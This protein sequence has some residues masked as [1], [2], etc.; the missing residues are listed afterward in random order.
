MKINGKEI[1]LINFN[2]V[3]D[4]RGGDEEYIFEGYAVTWDT[5]DSYDTTFR[6]GAFK[7]TITER[8]DKIKVLWNHDTDEPIGKI[9]EIRE[10][11]K[12]LFVR[13]KLTK[14]VT[15]A[16]DVYKNLQAGV[17]NTLSFGF[18]PLQSNRQDGA[19]RQITEVKLYEVS[20]V[21]F[22]ANETAVITSVR[23]ET[24]EKVVKERAED[25]D[26]T[27][28]D[29]L[30]RSNGYKLMDAL[31]E[32]VDDVWYSE[33]KE[34]VISKIDE[35][36]SKF[37]SAYLMWANAYVDR[38][39][40]IRKIAMAKNEL[41]KTFI[42][43]VTESIE[44]ISSRTAFT[45]NELKSLSRGSIL[46]LESRKKLVELPESIRSAHQKERS[47]AV[48]TLCSELRGSGFTEAEKMRFSALLGMETHNKDMEKSEE[49]VISLLGKIRNELK[50]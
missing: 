30:L 49:S 2:P 23:S 14:G 7:K 41:A 24:T 39:W 18:V 29:N 46:N 3:I 50:N 28:S 26:D 8:G 43:E 34:N 32:T 6:V 22:E 35:N 21:T 19:V 20:P 40:E 48:E 16:E 10:D 13:G 1:E 15:K 42:T 33:D 44:E 12:G 11:K 38:Y 31:Y 27:V 25:F 5:I 36:I 17:I 47:K 45:V 9:I 4:I 37:H